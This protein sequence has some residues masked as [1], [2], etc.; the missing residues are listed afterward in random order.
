[1]SQLSNNFLI[2]EK[3]YFE[4]GQI[5]EFI[6]RFNFEGET[7]LLSYLKINQ[8]NLEISRLDFLY[9]LFITYEITSDKSLAHAFIN[10]VNDSVNPQYLDFYD[11]DWY[12]EVSCIFEFNGNTDTGKLILKNQFNADSSS[13]WV[14]TGVRS[15]LLKMPNSKDSLQILSPVSHGTDFIAL[16][17]ILHDGENIQNYIT[18]DYTLDTL[19]YFMSLVHFNKIKLKQIYKVKYHFLQIPKWIFTVEYF[20]RKDLNSGWLISDLIRINME[21]KENYK[22]GILKIY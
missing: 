12:A 9:T 5:E 22:T 18:N 4:V 7:K 2:K 11:N 13:K 3:F 21:E 14:I 16:Y 19:T 10:Y 20:N 1:M 8:P 6:E 15:D 17:N